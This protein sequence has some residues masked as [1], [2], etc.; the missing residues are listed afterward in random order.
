[1]WS[2][3]LAVYC[4]GLNQGVNKKQVSGHLAWKKDEKKTDGLPDRPP[5]ETFSDCH[6]TPEKVTT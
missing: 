2:N 3:K 6:A 4:L 5:N 1:M